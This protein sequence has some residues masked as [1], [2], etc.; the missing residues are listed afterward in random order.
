MT[1]P[2]SVCADR[3]MVEMKSENFLLVGSNNII[4]VSEDDDEDDTLLF[5]TTEQRTECGVATVK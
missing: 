3:M 5:C 2:A 4:C 1:V